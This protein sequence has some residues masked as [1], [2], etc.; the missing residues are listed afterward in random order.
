MKPGSILKNP[1]VWGFVIGIVTL[2]AIRPLLRHI[3]EPPPVVGRLPDWSLV[4]STGKTFGSAELKGQVYI[5]SFFFTGCRSICPALMQNVKKL[6]AGFDERGIKGIRLV[7]ISVDPEDDTPPVL[8]A[9]GKELGV[10]PDRWTLVTGDPA[11]VRALVVDGFK[12]PMEK[13]PVE[14][15]SPMD[16]AHTG[17]LV[18]IDQTGGIR[19]YYD[20]TDMGLDEV[21]NRAQHVARPPR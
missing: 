21:Y 19:G 20:T 17:K 4:D 9:Y 14:P 3:P 8:A 16:I 11:K 7:S 2:T 15:P 6:Q 10:N 1:Y 5:A 12:T 13:A 18:L